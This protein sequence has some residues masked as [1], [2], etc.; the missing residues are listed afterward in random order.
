AGRIADRGWSRIGTGL[1][2]FAVALG[3]AVTLVVPAG[4]TAQVV[5]LVVAAV[6][7]DLGVQGNLVFGFRSI[8]GLDPERRSRINGI[9]MA[10]FFLAGS[11]GSVVGVWAYERSG[12]ALAASL[13]IALPLVALL[14]FLTE[15]QHD[16]REELT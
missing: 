11:A 10:T 16:L 15:E 13:G 3:F 14:Y 5:A 9:Y 6:V 12:W 7:I 4:T 2:I 8:F 1:A